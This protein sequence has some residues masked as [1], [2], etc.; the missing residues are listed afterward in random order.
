LLSKIEELIVTDMTKIF[1]AFLLTM[2]LVSFES[3]SQDTL[4][5]FTVVARPNNRNVVSWTNPYRTIS[6]ISIQRSNDSLRNFKTILTVPDPKVPQNG[7]VDAKAPTMNV[8]YRLFIVLDLGRYEFTKSKR[9]SADLGNQNNEA[10]LN[11]DNQRVKL[12]DSLS[13]KEV[14]AIRDKLDKPS[15]MSKPT[16]TPAPKPER[17]FV[18]K[19]KNVLSTVSEKN[20]KKF[21]DSLLYSTRDT[22][23]FESIDTVVIKPFVPKQNYMASKYVY[24]EK[25]GNV[26]IS[27][28]DA[29]HKKYSVSFFDENQTPLFEI[30]EVTSTSLTVDKTNFVH[31]GW[32]WFELYQDGK[33][34]EKHKFFIPKDF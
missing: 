31:S 30:K 4:P 33:L 8:F 7:F 22:L 15:T 23:I 11:N 3:N 10:V 34:K 13:S 5:R 19:R 20:F 24:T 14:R 16:S 25:Y 1:A 18:V 6:Q 32:F 2:V 26:M 21:R 29:A 28:P 9:P 27:L 12:S 17:F